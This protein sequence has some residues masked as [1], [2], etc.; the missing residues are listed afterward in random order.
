MY[1][2][3]EGI[4]TAGKSTQLDILANKYK[5]AVF[6]KEPGGTKIGSKLRQM[7]LGGEAKS[8]LAEM[9]L[10]LADRAEHMQEIVN[11]NKNKIVISD[12]S[13][14]SGIAYAK[15]L[16]LDDVIKLNLL[17][18]ENTLPSH[19]ILLKLSKEE[20]KKRLSLK[21]H[22]SIESRGI[23]YLIDIQNRMEETIKKLNLNYIFIDASLNIEEISKDIEDFLNE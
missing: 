3:I 7:V 5:D 13:M 1:I 18:T 2:V 14:I 9:F 21:E 8:K 4:D 17:A 16:P 19:V 22:D 15:H 23:D 20:L 12:R 10:F 6:T 11:K